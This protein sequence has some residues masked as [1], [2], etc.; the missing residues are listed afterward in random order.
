M[1]VYHGTDEDSAR[2]ILANGLD[3]L[4]WETAAGMAGPD[5]KGFSVSDSLDIARD[6]ARWRALERLG[7]ADRGMVLQADPDDLPLYQGQPGHWTDPGE[8]FV[9]PEDF[10]NVGSAIFQAVP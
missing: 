7:D 4:A 1:P 2:S 6:W 9:R 8:R 10:P 3:Q 5:P